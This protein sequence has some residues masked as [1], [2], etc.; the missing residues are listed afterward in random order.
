MASHAKQPTWHGFLLH[1]LRC[2]STSHPAQQAACGNKLITH[3]WVVK[4]RGSAGLWLQ[5]PFR[6]TAA[7]AHREAETKLYGCLQHNQRRDSSAPHGCSSR[8]VHYDGAMDGR[9]D[10]SHEQ[11][12]I[13]TLQPGQF[14]GSGAWK[15]VLYHFESC[16]RANRWSEGT[17]A[18]QLRF[19]LTGAAGAIVHK[20]PRSSSWSYQRI[21]NEIEAAYGPCSEHAAAI[22]IELR[23]RVRR[24]GESLHALRDDIYEKVSSFVYADRTEREQDAISVET[25]TNALADAEV[26]QRL[27]EE[28]P[29]TLASAYDIAHRYET[30]KRAAKTV[31]R[32]MQAGTLSA[33]ERR[34]RTATVHE[35]TSREPTGLAVRLVS[36]LEG[37]PKPHQRWQ[38]KGNDG[39]AKRSFRELVCHNCSGFGFI[40]QNC[41]SPHSPRPHNKSAA[42]TATQSPGTV[43]IRTKGQEDESCVQVTMHG[44]EIR[45]LLDSGARRSV[46]LLHYYSAIPAP[47]RPPIQPS[48]AR[49]LQGVGPNN[50]PVLGEVDVPLHIG[51][52]VC[53]VNFVVADIVGDTEVILGH[54][55]LL[56][57]RACLDYGRGEITLFGEKVPRCNADSKPEVHLVRVARRTVLR[58]GCEYIVPGTARRQP[59]VDGD[60]VLSPIKC[61]VERHRVL[62]AWVVVRTP[63]SINIPISF[64]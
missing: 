5:L 11:E 24:P 22:G 35:S 13:P 32:L 19:S 14:D 34:T 30:T 1:H 36:A 39:Q 7:S 4:L 44:L 49:T 37:E 62:E 56:Q 3:P 15:N 20:N 38:P 60:L 23:Q 59:A 17:M 58:P 2:P 54:P 16:A 48:V 8:L 21:V 28:K 52:R 41:P 50:L 45:A 27:L 47:A 26:V 10:D 25:F 31:T 9:D 29:H 57:A 40:Q 63:Q 6:V 51:S 42:P 12:R 53:N 33:V 64:F 61:F 46:L 18:V 55:F 43:V